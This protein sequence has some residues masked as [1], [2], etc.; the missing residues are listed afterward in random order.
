M[1]E[2]LVLL[3]VVKRAP[4]L[5]VFAQQSS[6]AQQSAAPAHDRRLEDQSYDNFL[7]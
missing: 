4:S 7:T 3:V 5:Q 2:F 6:V 1:Q